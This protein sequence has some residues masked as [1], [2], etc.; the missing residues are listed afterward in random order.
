MR[1]NISS[2]CYLEPEV[3]FSHAVRSGQFIIVS[4]TAP[5]GDGGQTG[6]V[7]SSIRPAFTLVEVNRLID[8]DWLVEVEFEAVTEP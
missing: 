5:I 7:F 8:P 1:T 4:G 6:G 3:G 2:G